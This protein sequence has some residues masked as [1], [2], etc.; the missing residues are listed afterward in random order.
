MQLGCGKDDQ[1]NSEAS[2]DQS[3]AIAATIS[4]NACTASE[5]FDCVL[6]HVTFYDERKLRAVG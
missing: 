1:R 3:N 6:E 2:S 4:A 5:S